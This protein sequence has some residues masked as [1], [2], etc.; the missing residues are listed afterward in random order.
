M[1]RG[2]S[3]PGGVSGARIG[4]VQG[5]M[6]ED[7]ERRKLVGLIGALA[8]GAS[9]ACAA[10]PVPSKDLSSLRT[11][12]ALD[13]KCP[14]ERLVIQ[15][16][17]EATRGVSG[18]GKRATYLNRAKP[19]EPGEKPDVDGRCDAWLQNSI[20]EAYPEP[21]PEP[22]PPAAPAPAPPAAQ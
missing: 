14:E 15:Q 11:R 6:N 2:R 20:G 18:C 4:Y 8:I 21:S 5:V 13:L 22:A 16:V 17:D 7:V 1:E 3:L 9:L 12:A 10:G 19:C